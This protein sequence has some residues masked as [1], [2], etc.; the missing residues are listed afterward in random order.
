C[1]LECNFG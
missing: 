1:G